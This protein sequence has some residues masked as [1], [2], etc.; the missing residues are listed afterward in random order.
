M[1]S[2][3]MLYYYFISFILSGNWNYMGK[4]VEPQDGISSNIWHNYGRLLLSHN[5]F[6]S[7]TYKLSLQ[8]F[9]VQ[10]LLGR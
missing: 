3:I 9:K 7:K 1:N 5:Y 10:N 4:F 6:F 2:F 8:V